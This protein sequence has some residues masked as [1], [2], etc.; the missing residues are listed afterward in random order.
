MPP[1]PN[2]HVLIINDKFTTQFESYQALS[3]H[4]KTALFFSVKDKL[5]QCHNGNNC[6]VQYTS[7]I[8]VEQNILLSN[9]I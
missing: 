7:I 5:Q 2:K 8:M 9:I 1:C 6:I 4:D 3:T